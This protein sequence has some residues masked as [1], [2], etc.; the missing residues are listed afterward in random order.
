MFY[1]G[2]R[3][4]FTFLKSMLSVE[5]LI[6]LSK[7]HGYQTVMLSDDNL[8]GAH[9]VFT[10]A[11]K[12]SI[13]PILSQVFMMDDT[14]C[15]V[16]V[17][18]QKGYFNL[19]A[20]NRIPK[21]SLSIEQLRS[22]QEGLT[23]TFHVRH[24][25]HLHTMLGDSN[26]QQFTHLYYGISVTDS[27]LFEDELKPIKD[28]IL[29]VYQPAYQTQE[30]KEVLH[31]LHL[32]EHK[33]DMESYPF[34]SS[35][36]LQTMWIEA[37]NAY[38]SFIKMHTFN[39]DM[40]VFGYPSIPLKEGVD[41]TSYLVSLAQVGLEKRIKLDK[42]KEIDVYKKRLSYELDVIIKMG[43]ERY[44]LI[45]FDLI[46]YAKQHH[47]LVGPGRGSAAGSL[48][49][50][51]LGITEVDP[52]KFKLLFERFLNPER[53]SM[54]DI[55]M[56]FPDDKR[57]QVIE[58]A[59]ERFGIEHL[60]SI[61]TYQTYALKSALRD[62]TKAL[63]L[64]QERAAYM[65]KSISEDTLDPLDRDMIRIKKYVDI[66]QGKPRQTGT[67]AAGIVFSETSLFNS[68]PL[69]QGVFS[70]Y[71]SQ[72]DQKTLESLGLLKMDFLGLRNLSIVSKT[73]E[74]I[75]STNPSFQLVNIPLDDQKTFDYISL[76]H[77]QGIFQLESEGM[78][79]TLIKL[80]PQT[81]ED[82]VVLL[83]L[84][85]P[86]PMEFIDTYIQ[87]KQGKP[88]E[89]MHEAIESILKP[90]YDIVIYQEQIME[91]AQ[92]FA[93]YT[94]AEADLLRRGI[95]KKDEVILKQEEKNFISK[96]INNH[97]NERDAKT[98]YDII[99]KF[100]DYGFN[101][102]HSVSYALLAYQMAY[103]KVNYPKD[104]MIALLNS[105]IGNE[106][107]TASYLDELKHMGFK[108]AS[109]NLL[110]SKLTY[111]VMDNTVLPP[112]H[113]IKSMG[114]KTAE[115]V[116]KSLEHHE[117]STFESLKTHLKGVLSESQLET[118]IYAQSVDMF[119][120]N[121]KTLIEN[122]SFK[123]TEYAKYVDQ[124]T[125]QSFDE[126]DTLY[127]MEKE[128]EA[129]GFNIKYRIHEFLDQFGHQHLNELKQL[130]RI[131][132]AGIL[133]KIKKIQTKKGDTMAFATIF[134]GYDYM[135]VT[136]FSEV[137]KNFES[138]PSKSYYIF[139]IERNI[140]QGKE[141]YV[142]KR[143]NPLEKM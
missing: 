117:I 58:Y 31:L 17:L 23:F 88:Y 36:S 90:T 51:V 24:V 4:T 9:D 42:I 73:M 95:A 69:Y 76:G 128:K 62:I 86:G 45:V 33:R 35:N 10:Y 92:V 64:S 123:T 91:I 2:N 32:L 80:N 134:D 14:T 114:E 55:D 85:R 67:H 135:E 103:L 27:A 22:H 7:R 59:K 15:F 20:L 133:T 124:M 8:H 102:S 87:R 127:L 141:S 11:K 96:A 131:T 61:T 122:K 143:I 12:A 6:T 113:I 100:S 104:F 72:W 37:F 34:I 53:K 52:I 82:I 29:P 1:V 97:R 89:V 136:L 21:S 112:I 47:I 81:F 111:Q 101:R 94:L 18:N 49:S 25:E 56:D 66:L 119:S 60:A 57:D 40:P 109:P 130:N 13:K 46:K 139:Q 107:L 71:Q 77:T 38:E 105:V 125:F 54:P 115:L 126:Y 16:S 44:F 5:D 118:C 68:I 121:T 39:L 74:S 3:S 78:R 138:Q 99:L 50:Y 70:F 142:L 140:Y 75:R 63:G 28:Q 106:T 84:Y 98:I 48:V 43:F 65:T 26:I 116:V 129:L 41:V 132:C 19:L 93:G 30:E 137:Y 83:A 108:I 110:Q 120:L 79:Q